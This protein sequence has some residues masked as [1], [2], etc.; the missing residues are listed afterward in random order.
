MTEAR[1]APPARSISSTVDVAV[2]PATAFAVFTD[3][4]DC[5]WQQGAIN[6]HDT[7]RAWEKRIEPGV[8]GRVLEVYDT[9]TGDGLELA[10]ITVWEPGARLAWVSS[11]DDVD[12]EVRFDGTG[13]ATTVTVV[14]TIPDGGDDRGGTA[15]LRMTPQWLP[16]WIERRDH[17]E[18]EPVVPHR[19]AV[20]VHY[21]RPA[22]AARYLRDVFGLDPSGGLPEEEPVGP[23]WIELHVANASILVFGTD[24]GE[25]AGPSSSHV[26]WVFVD[27][28]DEHH[29]RVA[30]R[31]GTIVTDIW[32]HGCRAYTAADLE[33]NRW[34]FAQ[35][36]PRQRAT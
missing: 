33:G 13:D 8:G 21:E 6:F 31:G 7:T 1:P 2:D 28:L 30:E 24:D 22:A 16:V 27:D 23:T 3:E 18:H 20:A 26:P 34:T 19:L 4:I 9:A 12:V 25:D 32:H 36:T 14:A 17:V 15:W 10:R 35:A 11:I 29:A 5:W